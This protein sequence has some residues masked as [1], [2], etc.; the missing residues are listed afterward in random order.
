MTEAEIETEQYG[1]C[2]VGA[3]MDE[4]ELAVE[5]VCVKSTGEVITDWAFESGLLSRK[6]SKIRS[7]CWD[8]E[9]DNQIDSLL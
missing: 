4:D 2:V 9:L 8:R 5:F 1:T 6:E 7:Q 3:E